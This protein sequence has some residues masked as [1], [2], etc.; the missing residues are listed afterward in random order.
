MLF[1]A[2]AAVSCGGPG[3]A[4]PRD[5]ASESAGGRQD[6]RSTGPEHPGRPSGPPPPEKVRAD[7]LAAVPVLMY[8]QIVEKPSSVYDRTPEDFRAE[9]ERLAR[10]KYVPVT[11]ADYA[12][13]RI[14]I[15][16]GTH[17]VV[18]TFD[19]ATDSQLRLGAD[20][21]PAEDCAVGILRDVA[22]EHP[23]F[24]ARA[25]FFVNDGAFAAT[26]QKKALAWL[27]EHGFEIGN[28]TLDHVSLAEGGAGE[29]RRQIAEE[30]ESVERDV[31]EAHVTSLALPF[32][33]QPDPASAALSGSAGG[34]AYEN[35]GVYLVGA[36]P[37]PSPYAESFDPEGIPRIRSAPAEGPE[38][39][40]SSAHWLSQLADGT[41]ARY[42]SDGDPDRVSYPKGTRTEPGGV[43]EGELRPY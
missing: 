13:G 15:P 29:A 41:V 20:G 18:L 9:L 42:T 22:R 27:H 21:E 30:Q 38:A 3:A 11:A 36:G 31:P 8:H 34:T 10:E 35:R 2:T 17:P 39:R 4:A 16:A 1:L 37:A 43:K 6:A 14:D 32:G 24:K 26:G 19:D 25:T 7:E 12:A 5:G 28:H 40:Y 33:I 23:R